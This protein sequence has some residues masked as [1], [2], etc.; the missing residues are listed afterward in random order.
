MCFIFSNII[1]LLKKKKYIINIKSIITDFEIKKQKLK[2]EN[3]NYIL[4][5]TFFLINMCDNY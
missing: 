1:Y 4:T 5:L 3:F 2:D